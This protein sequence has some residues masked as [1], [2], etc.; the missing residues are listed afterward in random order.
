MTLSNHKFR[1]LM[2][3]SPTMSM[4]Q[5]DCNNYRFISHQIGQYQP[6]IFAPKKE[7]CSTLHNSV[8]RPG[9]SREGKGRK[10]IKVEDC[11]FFNA[12]GKNHFLEFQANQ[13]FTAPKIR[14]CSDLFSKTGAALT[15]SNT[16]AV[17]KAP[18]CPTATPAMMR[19]PQ[20]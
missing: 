1:S 7:C 18:L 11:Q 10:K 6:S 9:K 2:V 20:L 16:F 3:I 17:Q 4:H 13:C 14:F 5:I 12:N 15:K 8:P 19:N